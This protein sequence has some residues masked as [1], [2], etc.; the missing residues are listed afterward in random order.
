MIKLE[1]IEKYSKYLEYRG[2][3]GCTNHGVMNNEIYGYG[4]AARL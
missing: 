3:L 1:M 2:I 4:Y